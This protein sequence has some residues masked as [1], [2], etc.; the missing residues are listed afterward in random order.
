M[1]GRIIPRLTHED[2]VFCRLPH[3]RARMRYL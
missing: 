1:I 3:L 2:F